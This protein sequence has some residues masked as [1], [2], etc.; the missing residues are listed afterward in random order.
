MRCT[1]TVIYYTKARPQHRELRALLFALN[2]QGCVAPSEARHIRVLL[3]PHVHKIK[4]IFQ[5]ID[6]LNNVLLLS[7]ER[8]PRLARLLKAQ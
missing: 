3:S 6:Y 1:H 7:K 8:P 5:L 4:G 2:F